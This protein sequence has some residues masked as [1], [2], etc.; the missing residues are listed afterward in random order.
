MQR[1]WTDDPA[2][3]VAAYR[4]HI[5]SAAIEDFH[6]AVRAHQSGVDAC[7]C[8]GFIHPETV[9]SRRSLMAISRMIGNP[10]LGMDAWVCCIAGSGFWAA[11]GRG[12]AASVRLATRPTAPVEITATMEETVRWLEARGL[13]APSPDVQ[14]EVLALGE[15]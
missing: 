6:A 3:V 5:A 9:I 7:T 15:T 12:M 14:R 1:F 4:G 10:A 11:T 8:V 13:P 2:C